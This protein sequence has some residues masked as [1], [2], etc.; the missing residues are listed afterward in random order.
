[1]LKADH[2]EVEGMFAEL[3]KTNSD[4]RK[5][6]LAERICNALKAHTIIEEEIFYPAF[7][8]ATDDKDIHHEAEVEHEG[9]KHL[10]GEIEAAGPDDDYFE[11]RMSV[12]SE[13]IKHHVKEEEKR[14][15]MLAKAKSSDMDLAALGEQ[16]LKRKTEALAQMDG[17]GM[18]SRMPRGA[19][20]RPMGAG[21]TGRGM[22]E[23]ARR[24]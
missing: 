3:E 10:I 2:R 13:M 21:R 20:G 7:L 17:A 15:G 24:H 16:M 9:A 1:M 4:S 12:L 19:R 8:E 6:D 22:Q 18:R 14:G 23:S 5:Q 11:A